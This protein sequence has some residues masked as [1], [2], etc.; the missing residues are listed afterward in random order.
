MFALTV[1]LAVTT[2]LSFCFS[3]TRRIGILTIALLSF[4]FPRYAAVLLLIGVVAAA[5]HYFRNH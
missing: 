4:L 2:V 3:S 5:F 1:A